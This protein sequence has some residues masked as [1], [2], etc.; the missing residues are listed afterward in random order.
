MFNNPMHQVINAVSAFAGLL[1]NQGHHEPINHY[2]KK[3]NRAGT[4]SNR[5]G[6]KCQETGRHAF[7]FE[8]RV[9]G[10][11]GIAT[12]KCARCNQRTT[13]HI[14]NKGGNKINRTRS[15]RKSG[16]IRHQPIKAY[17]ALAL[18]PSIGTYRSGPG[19]PSKP[20]V[21]IVTR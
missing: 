21:M 15:E 13:T 11:T 10:C 1:A 16:I 4:R 5:G 7:R 20:P 18:L 14:K 19:G 3:R 9:I 17:A 6:E 8:S 2:T 12:F